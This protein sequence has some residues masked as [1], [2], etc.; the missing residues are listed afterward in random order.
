MCCTKQPEKCHLILSC[1]QCLCVRVFQCPPAGWLVLL[2]RLTGTVCGAR[3]GTITSCVPLKMMSVTSL[4][5]F[6]ERLISWLHERHA[7]LHAVDQTYSVPSYQ[8]LALQQHGLSNITPTSS[9]TSACLHAAPI[10]VQASLQTT[11]LLCGVPNH[12]SS[13]WHEHQPS[14]NGHLGTSHCILPPLP[15]GWPTFTSSV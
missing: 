10:T 3:V 1:G 13:W 9:S 5:A 6:W 12:S 14:N 15:Y 11:A 7:S 2:M 8:Q 4:R